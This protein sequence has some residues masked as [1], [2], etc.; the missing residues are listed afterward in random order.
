MTFLDLSNKFKGRFQAKSKKDASKE[1][2]IIFELKEPY[3]LEALNIL[4]KPSGLFIRL[5]YRMVWFKIE[6]PQDL[7]GVNCLMALR[8]TTQAKI[9]PL[10]FG[11]VRNVMDMGNIFYLEIELADFVEYDSGKESRRKQLE[12]FNRK[13][14]DGPAHGIGNTKKAGMDKLIFWTPS[15]L[16]EFKNPNYFE[17][18]LE[19]RQIARWSILT[20]VLIENERFKKVNFL[21]VAFVGEGTSD[22]GK[23]SVI[24]GGAIIIDGNKSYS[25]EVMQRRENVQPVKE[26]ELGFD[27]T[28]LK[29]V[30]DRQIA[31]SR[32]DL[33]K[34][35]FYS[36]QSESQERVSV[37]IVSE[38]PVNLKNPDFLPLTFPVRIKQKSI[39]LS[40]GKAIVFVLSVSILI[41]PALLKDILNHVLPTASPENFEGI[42]NSLI[43]VAII[44]SDSIPTIG[45]S[46]ISKFYRVG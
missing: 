37:I 36:T 39:M 31:V 18:N 7:V 13:L 29:S 4:A 26:I 10:R 25:F 40:V 33:L 41:F 46:I 19:R 42:K 3:A 14:T 23:K 34:F 45:K 44:T 11:V 15:Y 38:K 5:R 22:M 35:F 17:K 24:N 21:Y 27:N 12:E 2:I 20:D 8:I 30:L 28:S 43:I 32:Y 9:I 6:S 16:H 1:A